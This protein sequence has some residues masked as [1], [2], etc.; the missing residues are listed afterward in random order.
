MRLTFE[1][2]AE[3][4]RYT[5][6]VI[7][8]NTKKKVWLGGVECVKQTTKKRTWVAT[9]RGHKALYGVYT[10]RKAAGTDL[11]TEQYDLVVEE[12]KK[13]GGTVT[14]D[15]EEQGQKAA[16][17]KAAQAEASRTLAEKGW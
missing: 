13:H 15:D 14:A 2:S 4:G 5:V 7:P 12:I 10:N 8:A 11:L 16:E 17:R 6:Y 1:Q 9:D 3:V